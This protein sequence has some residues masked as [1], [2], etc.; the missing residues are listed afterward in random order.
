MIEW[1]RDADNRNGVGLALAALLWLCVS[2][3]AGRRGWHLIA[4]WFA[5]MAGYFAIRAGSRFSHF[6]PGRL[7]PDSPLLEVSLWA[8]NVMMLVVWV[9][10]QRGWYQRRE[11]EHP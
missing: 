2:W 8:M 10:L 3:Q 7:S 4:L 9:A 1:L 6:A 11:R 5:V